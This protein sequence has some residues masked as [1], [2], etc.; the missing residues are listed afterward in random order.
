MDEIQND[1]T[2]HN[3][4]QRKQEMIMRMKKAMQQVKGNLENAK[5]AQKEKSDSKVKIK[6]IIV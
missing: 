1:R 6:L 5:T 2:Y 3:L 4:D